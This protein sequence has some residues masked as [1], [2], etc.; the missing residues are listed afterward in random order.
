MC[1]FSNRFYLIYHLPLHFNRNFQKWCNFK[2]SLSFNENILAIL[3][4]SMTFLS[5]LSINLY[6]NK[7]FAVDL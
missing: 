1:I 6:P 4:M 7:T 5:L 3:R 2:S